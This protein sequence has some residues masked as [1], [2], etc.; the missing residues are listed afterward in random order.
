[1]KQKLRTITALLPVLCL[2]SACTDQKKTELIDAG[3]N[4]LL[5]MGMAFAVLIL[6]SLVISLFPLINKTQTPHVHQEQAKAKKREVPS[7]GS[8]NEPE[9]VWTGPEE[10]EISAV[11]SAAIAAYESETE[12]RGSGGYFVRSVRKRRNSSRLYR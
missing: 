4:T 6:I 2:L 12:G 7:S 10:D 3:L 1:M 8:E 5:G 9:N 11:I